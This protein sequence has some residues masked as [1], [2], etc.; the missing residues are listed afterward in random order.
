MSDLEHGS[1]VGGSLILTQANITQHDHSLIDIVDVGNSAYYNKS[2]STTSGD[3]N[4]IA[5]S[6]AVND[7]RLTLGTS[8]FHNKSDS[9]TSTSTNSIATSKALNDGLVN[10]RRDIIHVGGRVT[11]GGVLTGGGGYAVVYGS[12][13]R[14]HFSAPLDTS[15]YVPIVT[16]ITGDIH[17]NYNVSFASTY[18]D[19]TPRSVGLGTAWDSGEI[20]GVW[21]TYENHSRAFNFVIV[22]V[23]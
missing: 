16:G 2:D 17:D 8:A 23:A 19:V 20:S 15:K 11:D 14:I 7:L 22:R 5:T 9:F 4:S 6:K 10:A 1:T 18:M 12:F 3:T 13:V 21:F